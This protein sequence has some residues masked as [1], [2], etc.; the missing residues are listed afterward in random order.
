MV[1]YL[2]RLSFDYILDWNDFGFKFAMLFS[3]KN[4]IWR[5]PGSV[6]SYKLRHILGSGLV[7]MTIW[8][9][10][11]PMIYRNL[12]ENTYPADQTFL[13]MICVNILF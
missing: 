10:P 5:P 3:P 1:L 2:N 6:S 8:T 4:V 13:Q 7:E 12:Y 11:K 9:D